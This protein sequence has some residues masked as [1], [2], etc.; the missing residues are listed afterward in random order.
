VDPVNVIDP[1]GNF[2]LTEASVTTNIV[3]TLTS[4]QV[5]NAFNT[6]DLLGVS[7][8]SIETARNVNRVIG[9]A[10]LGGAGVQIV[11]ILSKKTGALLAKNSKRI[12]DSN[13]QTIALGL[14]ENLGEFTHVVKKLGDTDNLV[15]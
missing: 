2:G 10:A 8:A 5:E 9:F 4:L 11:K 1:S 12:V 13:R 7:D 14:R 6:L 15:T 3:I